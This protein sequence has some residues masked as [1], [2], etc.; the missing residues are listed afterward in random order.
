MRLSNGT[1]ITFGSD[2]L[3]HAILIDGL[4]DNVVLS[5]APEW[6]IWRD[7]SNMNDKRRCWRIPLG[8]SLERTSNQCP[9]DFFIFLKNALDKIETSIIHP[10]L[11]NGFESEAKRVFPAISELANE[12]FSSFIQLLRTEFGVNE[13][14]E[15]S[16]SMSKFI[17]D[18]GPALIVVVDGKPAILPEIPPVYLAP[19]DWNLSMW[20][21]NNHMVGPLLEDGLEEEKQIQFPGLSVP[22]NEL[23]SSQK[24][25]Y[26]FHMARFILFF[27]AWVGLPETP[28]LLEFIRLYK[29]GTRVLESVIK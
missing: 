10:A 27:E 8:K 14:I 26:Y 23:T 3:G 5:Q 29:K 16:K 7:A 24:G 11:A 2:N 4:L 17:D 19:N 20:R 22:P 6:T 9:D 25:I 12:E 18:I 1:N 28:Y 21:I 15:K 13:E